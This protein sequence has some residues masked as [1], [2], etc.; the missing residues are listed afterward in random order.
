MKLSKATRAI[1]KGYDRGYAKGFEAGMALAVIGYREGLDAAAE[2]KAERE[3]DIAAALEK[4][5]ECE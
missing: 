3:A 4:M 2:Y 5:T 1:L